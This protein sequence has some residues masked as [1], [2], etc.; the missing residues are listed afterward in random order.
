MCSIG[1]DVGMLASKVLVQVFGIQ[2][3]CKFAASVG[4]VRSQLLVELLHVGKLGL[5]GRVL[6]SVTGLVDYSDG[7]AI[8][9]RLLQGRQEVTSEDYVGPDITQAAQFVKF[10]PESRLHLVVTQSMFTYMWFI[11]M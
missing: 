2:D 4:W 6:V 8:C 7:V 5:L 11:A 3:S 9:C 1:I 10:S